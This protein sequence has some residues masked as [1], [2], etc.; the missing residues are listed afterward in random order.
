MICYC[1]GGAAEHDVF[2]GISNFDDIAIPEI[3]IRLRSTEPMAVLTA[4]SSSIQLLLIA[5]CSR[6]AHL[7]HL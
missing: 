5:Q 1:I 7:S 4:F 3:R 2:E 6:R